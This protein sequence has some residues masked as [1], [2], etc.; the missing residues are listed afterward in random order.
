MSEIQ[1][2]DWRA[3][4]LA[5]GIPASEGI[6]RSMESLER[7]FAV[8]RAKIDLLDEPILQPLLAEQEPSR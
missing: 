8:V 3:I 1:Q 2:P 7:D 6:V 5:R 4:A